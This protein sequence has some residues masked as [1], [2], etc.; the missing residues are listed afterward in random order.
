MGHSTASAKFFA[1]R[2]A[3]KFLCHFASW[4]LCVNNS[5]CKR[6]F[7][8][9]PPAAARRSAASRKSTPPCAK[10]PKARRSFYSHP[11]RLPLATLLMGL[12]FWLMDTG[13]DDAVLAFAC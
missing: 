6:A 4:R 5:P 9:A 1:K 7:S 11:N 12:P 3:I 13:L 8:S 10:I 2:P